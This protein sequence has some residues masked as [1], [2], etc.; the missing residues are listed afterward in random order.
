MA[1]RAAERAT[2]RATEVEGGGAG[3]ATLT[4]HGAA[5]R[6]G[7]YRWTEERLF[8]LTGTWAAAPGLVDVARVH[9]FEAS[10][11]HAWHAQLWADRLPVLAGVDPEGLTRPVGAR[12]ASLLTALE[13]AEVPEPSPGAEAPRGV[14][15]VAGLTVE[16]LPRLLGSYAEFGRRLVPVTDGPSI[17]ALTLVVRD[18]EEELAAAGTLLGGLAGSSAAEE[19]ARALGEGLFLEAG[20]DGAHADDLFPWPEGDSTW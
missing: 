3:G 1:E 4:I 18:V 19:W 6:L 20:G 2:E 8:E 10:T 9:L 15:F 13:P 11:Q 7:A 17:R 14:R 12:A 5:V 16:V